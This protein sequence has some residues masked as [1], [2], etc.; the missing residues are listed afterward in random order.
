MPFCASAIDAAP[1][2]VLIVD[3]DGRIVLVNQQLERRFRLQSGRT[4]R[5]DRATAC[6]PR[7]QQSAH[8]VHRHAFMLDATERPMG[9][10]RVLFGRR[11]DGSEFQVEIGLNPIETD[12][13]VFVVASVVDTT[14]RRDLSR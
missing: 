10:G 9:S 4:R 11:R 13:G 1:S 5:T 3:A 8:A 12:R 7:A 6:C 2:G 14:E